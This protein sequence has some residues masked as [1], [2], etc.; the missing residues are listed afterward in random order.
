M[1]INRHP[2]RPP[3]SPSSYLHPSTQ[4]GNIFSSKVDPGIMKCHHKRYNY[5][6]TRTGTLAGT[7]GKSQCCGRTVVGGVEFGGFEERRFVVRSSCTRKSEFPNS[8]SEVSAGT[9]TEV[10]SP[11]RKVGRISQ[12][13]LRN[14]R[15]LR[16]AASGYL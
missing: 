5:G 3:V 7:G 8:Q 1:S 10:G 14:P 6:E 15:W 2:S 11:T 16:Y 13:R 9:R 4:S 12:P